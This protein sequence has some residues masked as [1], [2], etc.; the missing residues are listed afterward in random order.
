MTA[1]EAKSGASAAL[2]AAQM[3]AQFATP[4]AGRQDITIGQSA[5]QSPVGPIV[6]SL[7]KIG[8]DITGPRTSGIDLARQQLQAQQRTADNTSKLV[9]QMSKSSSSSMPTIT[10]Q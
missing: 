2:T 7:A 10:Y 3:R 1:I 9:D 4:A 8:G 6:S 5:A